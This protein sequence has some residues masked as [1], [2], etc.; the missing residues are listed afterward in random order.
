MS[1][2][3]QYHLTLKNIY[4]R[5]FA[6]K[7]LVKLIHGNRLLPWI[8]NNFQVRGDIFH[9]SSPMCYYRITTRS[10]FP[11]TFSLVKE[12]ALPHISE[13]RELRNSGELLRKFKTI[14]TKEEILAVAAVWS[15]DNYI[16]LYYQRMFNWYTI[17]YKSLVL[18]PEEELKEDVLVY[19]RG[20]T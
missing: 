11:R 1:R 3:P 6:R 19:Q 4:R 13:I 9:N 17:V 16:P 20:N 7:P 15:V 14:E 5:I 8:A 10:I 2:A 18:N 12:R